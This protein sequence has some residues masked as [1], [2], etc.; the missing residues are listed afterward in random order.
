LGTVGELELK[1]QI[2]E[3][4]QKKT[5]TWVWPG[6]KWKIWSSVW[7]NFRGREEKPYLWPYLDRIKLHRNPK[8]G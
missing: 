7:V 5:V 1:I 3:K 6:E 4:R 2:E 8:E